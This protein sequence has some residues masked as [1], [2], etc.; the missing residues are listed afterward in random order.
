MRAVAR[1]RPDILE[2]AMWETPDG[3][4]IVRLHKV[5]LA[6]F[7]AFPT[8]ETIDELVSREVPI[9]K[10]S[11]EAYGISASRTSWAAV[12]EKALAAVDKHWTAGRIKLNDD[13]WR[14][15]AELSG[16]RN[17]DDIK[18]LTD[19]RGYTRLNR[20]LTYPEMAEVMAE[21]TGERASAFLLQS[22]KVERAIAHLVSERKPIIVSTLRQ[23]Q[24]A[25]PD[26]YGLASGHAYEVTGVEDGKIIM[27]NPWGFNDPAPVPADKFLKEFERLIVTLG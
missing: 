19:A 3:R 5:K 17:E 23:G 26:A 9:W 12:A 27:K 11:G 25:D 2:S 21:V 18:T 8:G 16:L 13:L 1:L 24:G 15:Q 10:G 4:V 6:G 14:Q 7:E 22:R 20:G